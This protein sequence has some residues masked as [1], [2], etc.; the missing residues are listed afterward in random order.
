MALYSTPLTDLRK[1]LNQ[2]DDEI[3]EL[4]RKRMNL[5]ENLSYYKI[6]ASLP[7]EDS[8]REFDKIKRACT[9]LGSPYDKYLHF[10][11][12]GLFDASKALQKDLRN[13]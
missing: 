3:I 10:F 9:Q 6:S 12:T 2:I 13:E 11:M 4:F 7:V 8:P 5:V 1:E